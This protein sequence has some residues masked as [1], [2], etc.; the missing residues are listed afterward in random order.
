M[1]IVYSGNSEILVTTPEKESLMLL[2]YFE[3]GGR[4]LE[5]YD[6]ET[7]AHVVEISARLTSQCAVPTAR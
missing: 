5:E 1:L 4:D 2:E 3:E 7:C 6:R